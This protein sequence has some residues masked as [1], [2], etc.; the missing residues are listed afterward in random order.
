[1]PRLVACRQGSVISILDSEDTEQAD[2]RGGRSPWFATSSHPPRSRPQREP[3]MRCADRRRRHHRIAGRRA[4][5]AP[6]ARRRHRRS[7]I[8]GPRQHRRLDL[9]AAVGN[10]PPLRA[11]ERSSMASSGPSRAYRA[12]LRCRRR[13]EIAGPASS[14]SPATCATRIRCYLAA[15]DSGSRSA[16]RASTART[17]AGLPGDFLDHAMLLD[18]SASPAPARSCRRARPMPIRCNWRT[19]C[20]D[21]RHRA[22]RPAVRGRGRRIRCRRRARSVSV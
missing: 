18:V 13:A 12:S 21:D 2:L 19:A 3:Q 10:R 6:G 14:A 16:R 4:P 20:S 1:M 7:R 11:A 9:D 8:A 5:D 17:R 22:R 15:G